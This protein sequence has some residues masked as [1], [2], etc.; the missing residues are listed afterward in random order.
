MAAT[1]RILY[2]VALDATEAAVTWQVTELARAWS[3]PVVLLARRERRPWKFGPGR[4]AEETARKLSAIAVRMKGYVT[5]IRVTEDPLPAAAVRVAEEIGAE[6]IAIGAGER[7]N[8]QPEHA[9]PDALAIAREA[10][11]DVLLCKP[12][13]DPYVG[14][15]LC[16]ADTTP[17]A[18]SAVLR[19]LELSRRFNALL[20]IVSV[21]SEPMWTA[22]DDPEDQVRHQH[23][24]QKA[25]LDQ[26]DLRGVA[27]SRSVVWSRS[28]A[29]EILDEAQRYSEGLLVIGASS[30]APL[31]GGQLGPNAQAILD[32]C[33]CSLLIV[34]K[35]QPSLR[36]R[37][38][39]P[40]Q[41]ASTESIC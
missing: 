11:V 31:P 27:L 39:R 34:K 23:E 7:A 9:N 3:A 41:P 38:G 17:A 35:L 40:A 28:A 29:V 13:A 19:A 36:A 21:M 22:A 4:R 32:A 18:G 24:G 30:H 10:H 37:S 25:F 33:P 16:A 12:F 8:T 5:D 6:L 15:V 2:V 20:R 26:F 1:R 14:H